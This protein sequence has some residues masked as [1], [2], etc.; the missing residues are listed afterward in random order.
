MHNARVIDCARTDCQGFHGAS[1]RVGV[2]GR[3]IR[4]TGLMAMAV[5]GLATTAS[6]Q[7]VANYNIQ[8]VG[9]FDAAHTSSGGRSTVFTALGEEGV[10]GGYSFRYDPTGFQIGRD[11]WMWLGSSTVQVGLTGGVNTGANGRQETE[12]RYLAA[13][14]GGR[15]TGLST[16]Y[17]GPFESN[18]GQSAWVFDGTTTRPIGLTGTGYTAPTSGYQYSEPLY[19]ND[20][21][22][23]VGY[24]FRYDA[25]DSPNGADTW[26]WDGTGGNTTR[27]INLT[28]PANTGQT[29]YRSSGPR[30]QNAAG[31]VVGYSN[32]VTGEFTPNGQ[33]IWVFRGSAAT[34]TT[35]RIGLVSGAYIGS[36]GYASSEVDFQ[37]ES[38]V[39][40]G[41]SDRILDVNTTNGRDAWVWN[42]S[43]T[44]QAG[45]TTAAYTGS[46]GFRFSMPTGAGTG[47]RAIGFSARITGENTNNGQD[48]WRFNGTT[49]QLIN[50][51]T[52]FYTGNAGY[53]DA[54]AR[55]INASGQVAGIAARV[56]NAN[57]SLGQDAWVY[58]GTTTRTISPTGVGYTYSREGRPVYDARPL[59]LTEVG[60][61]VGTSTRFDA[62]SGFGNGQDA[63][64]WDPL[65][66]SGAGATQVIGLTTPAHTGSNGYRINQTREVL[67]NGQAWG[68]T[69]RITNENNGNGR[70]AWVW[71]RGANGAAGTTSQLGLTGGIYTS[72]VGFQQTEV[73]F[74]NASGVIV[75]YSYRTFE[76][77]GNIGVDAWYYDPATNTT[78]TLPSNVRTGYDNFASAAAQVLTPDGFMLGSYYYFEN[79]NGNGELRAFAFRPDRGFIELGNLLPGGA[80]AHG[81]RVLAYPEYASSSTNII[82]AGDINNQFGSSSVFAISPLLCAGPVITQQPVS[83][84]VCPGR[85]TAVSVGVSTNGTATYQWLKNG[86]PIS[87]ATNPSAATPSLILPS[88]AAGDVGSYACSI[89]TSC[90]S[91]LTPVANLT[92]LEATSPACLP[93][94]CNPDV[95]GDGNA[96]QGDIDYL[97][98]V[99][100]GGS[101]PANVSADFNQD[102]NA[103]QGDVDALINVVA[104]GA[105]P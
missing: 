32:R 21:G 48:V 90:S 87:G 28:A 46:A 13:A 89:T 95:N 18:I 14:G 97:I 37:S 40:A 33:D 63:W 80:N 41:S 93:P 42:G 84:S 52:G 47:G 69:S 1:S 59:Y 73:Q 22:Q 99:V 79:G 61:V 27:I 34:G 77:Y 100:A 3:A 105:C 72:P 58:D 38:G 25:A 104:G 23:V 74:Q 78:Y 24:S 88:F 94:T 19:F 82:G 70:D 49:T 81:W 64:A 53:R 76:D 31:Q 85:R 12:F 2:L 83:Q 50:P 68:Y 54:D 98:N 15:A 56:F 36:A 86:V 51:T 91:I 5:A 75:G 103:D 62:N 92:L 26:V 66:N 67:P 57:D 71:R 60:V 35:Q 43:T 101:N 11:A 96:D 6:A 7:W 9:L 29:G 30:F 20:A 39:I 8:R 55:L 16:R 44:Q 45:L 17:S 10:V 102:G 65:R 4:M